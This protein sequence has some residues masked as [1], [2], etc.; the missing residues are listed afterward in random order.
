MCT[1]ITEKK[2]YVKIEHTLPTK[3]E[4]NGSFFDHTSYILY[5]TY[6]CI[7]V[8]M[9]VDVPITKRNGYEIQYKNQQFEILNCK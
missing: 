5:Y 3:F 2:K 9:Y 6:V 7:Y 1:N 8:C 4:N